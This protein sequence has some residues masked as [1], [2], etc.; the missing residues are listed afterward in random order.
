MKTWLLRILGFI[1]AL[2]GLGYWVKDRQLEKERSDNEQLRRQKHLEEKSAEQREKL[3]KLRRRH[4]DAREEIERE[5]E[6]DVRS[7]RRDHFERQ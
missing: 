1:L 4:Q 5:V 2:V 3:K 6:D 7:G